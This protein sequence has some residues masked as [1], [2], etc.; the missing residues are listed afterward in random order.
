[1]KSLQL[2]KRSPLDRMLAFNLVCI[3]Y[4]VC[5]CLTGTLEHYNDVFLIL[6]ICCCF[7]NLL[8]V[9]GSF[10]SSLTGQRLLDKAMSTS[11]ELHAFASTCKRPPEC[12][13]AFTNTDPGE[14]VWVL[15]YTVLIP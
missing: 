12:H 11:A 3:K 14:L 7:S 4:I 9:P 1:M 15:I 10:D 13:D 5:T 2:Q 6:L 8:K